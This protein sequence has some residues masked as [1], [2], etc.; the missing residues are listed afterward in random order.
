MN[1]SEKCGDAHVRSRDVGSC[2]ATGGP[3]LP[4]RVHCVLD[5][6]TRQFGAMGVDHRGHVPPI[7]NVQKEERKSATDKAKQNRFYRSP[8][9]IDTYTRALFK[10]LTS[11]RGFRHFVFFFKELFASIA[12]NA[13]SDDSVRVYNLHEYDYYCDYLLVIPDQLILL[14]R[15]VP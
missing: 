2:A 13:L 8:Q 1:P 11:E 9:H 3:Y 5:F 15:S 4:C 6:P 12:C 10:G 14:L 7:T